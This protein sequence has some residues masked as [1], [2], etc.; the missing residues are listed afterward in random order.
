MTSVALLGIGSTNFH[1]TI[2][3]PEGDFVT[4]I[5][6]ESTEPHRLEQ[7]LLERVDTLQSVQPLDAIAISIP[8][9][10]DPDAGIVRKF[11][12]PEG[13]VLENLDLRSPLEDAFGIPVVLENDCTA[14]A[15]G[16]LYFGQRE[17]H[18]C[19]LHVTFGTGIG[20]GVV[21]NGQV[22]RGE[23]G[24]AGEFGLLPVAPESDLSSTGVTGAWE[25]FC[26]GRGIPRYVR[27]RLETDGEWA[28]EDTE[29][30]QSVANGDSLSA[31]MVFT[32]AAEGDPFA[33][34]SLEQL[35]RYNAAGIGALCNAF[36][37]GLVTLGG[38]VA[39]N[40]QEWLLEG[41]ERYLEAY[42]FVD[43]PS[44]SIT[45]LG[46]EI[47]LYGALGAW[48]ERAERTRVDLFPSS[49]KS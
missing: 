15:L 43:R 46:E 36:N 42:C 26:S 34:S 1:A 45:P 20:G 8:G 48:L 38:G 6:S 19:V 33:Q 18:D 17:A 27:H 35:S 14:S 29:F 3:T 47:G 40:N 41:I 11:D 28:A 24:Q 49:R 4:E 7:Q 25:A 2:G 12:T 21:E 13:E 22:L 44:L 31:P 30:T 23:S 32:A 39:L 16:E 37:P 5:R 9:L 10:V